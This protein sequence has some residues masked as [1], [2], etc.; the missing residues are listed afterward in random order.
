MKKKLS[1]CSD[2]VKSAGIWGKCLSKYKIKLYFKSSQTKFSQAPSK[3]SM[4]QISFS[5][6]I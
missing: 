5:F 6:V 4:S 1:L 3:V 2:T